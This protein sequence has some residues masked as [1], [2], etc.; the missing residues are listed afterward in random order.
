MLTKSRI[1]IKR[2]ALIAALQAGAA[3]DYAMVKSRRQFKHEKPEKTAYVR[4]TLGPSVVATAI[5]K[6]YGGIISR[7]DRKALAKHTGQSRTLF[8]SHQ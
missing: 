2:I 8:Y 7:A 1:S 3:R 5:K 4:G 6:Q